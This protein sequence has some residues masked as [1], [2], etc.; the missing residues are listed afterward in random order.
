MSKD[1]SD[2]F[3]RK[4]DW[5]I[6]KDDL[7]TAYLIPYLGKILYS[8]RPLLYVDGFAGPGRFDDGEP[9]SPV[10]ACE[11]M[12][13][14]L[15]RP[16][17]SPRLDAIFIEKNHNK[18]LENE[19]QKFPFAQVIPGKYENE[20]LNVKKHGNGRNLFLYVDPYG[21]KYLDCSLFDDVS[22]LYDSA[23]V[24]LNFNSFGFIR[25]A[26]RLFKTECNVGE[27]SELEEREPWNEQDDTDAAAKLSKIV[28]GDYWKSV[29]EEYKI[30]NI[31]GYEAEVKLAKLFC[32]RLASSFNY[33]LNI[34]IR[35]GETHRP[36]YRMI[37]MS[38]HQDG[39][40][41]MYDNMQKRLDELQ[42]IQRENQQS[43]FWQDSEGKILLDLNL[44]LHEFE[45][46]ICSFEEYELLEKAIA[47]FIVKIDLGVSLKEL[48]TKIRE[49]GEAGIIDIKRNP[50]LTKTGK[51]SSFMESKGNRQSNWIRKHHGKMLYKNKA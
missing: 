9:G 5:S 25:A 15:T 26:C 6:I 18:A 34:P 40:L 11:Q 10:I 8:P 23:E 31:D 21:I 14:A 49:M 12:M 47:S 39:C 4:N 45:K 30:G 51:K 44:V 1:N 16:T 20:I 38:N 22:R 46:H 36:K 41:L 48:R 50:E 42:C 2:F 29:I 33:V 28:G 13:G 37:H 35:L 19:L 7:L 3:K 32:K 27:L 17:K 43:L 24:L